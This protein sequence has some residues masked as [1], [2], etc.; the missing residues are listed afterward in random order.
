MAA[1][2]S[3]TAQLRAQIQVER[4]ELE[5]SV[6]ELKSSAVDTAIRAGIAVAAL[7]GLVV[8]VKLIARL[9]R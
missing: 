5:A 7:V 2:P 1:D 3:Q 6:D 4:A 8:T 9:L